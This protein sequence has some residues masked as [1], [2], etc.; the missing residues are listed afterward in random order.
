VVNVSYVLDTASGM[1]G[2]HVG[3]LIFLKLMIYEMSD[4]FSL[5]DDVFQKHERD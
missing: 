5:Y 3:R 4:E 1:N 2:C